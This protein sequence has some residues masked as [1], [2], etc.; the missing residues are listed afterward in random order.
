M[1][2]KKFVFTISYT[3]IYRS[4]YK[5]LFETEPLSNGNRGLVRSL[6]HRGKTSHRKNHVKKEG[7]YKYQI[8]FMNGLKTIIIVQKADTVAGKTGGSCLV[9]L[10]VG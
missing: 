2:H 5:G 7:K 9:T 3:T 1:K 8:L 4:I 6:R 10:T